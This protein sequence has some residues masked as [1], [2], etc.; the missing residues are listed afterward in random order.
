MQVSEITLLLVISNV[1]SNFKC[2]LS[3]QAGQ[4]SFFGQ[5]E[6]WYLIEETIAY[7]HGDAQQWKDSFLR[8]FPSGDDF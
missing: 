6:R 8:T 2:A 4:E 3:F 7:I 5:L 1:I